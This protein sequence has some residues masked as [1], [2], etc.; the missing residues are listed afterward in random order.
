[1]CNS[2][3]DI[4]VTKY[5][6]LTKMYLYLSFRRDLT[7]KVPMW[8]QYW[9]IDLRIGVASI[10]IINVRHVTLSYGECYR[11]GIGVQ[12]RCYNGWISPQI[13]R[14]YAINSKA[15]ISLTLDS[16]CES[17]S[18]L[19][20]YSRLS[21]YV[22]TVPNW[23]LVRLGHSDKLC[24]HGDHGST[25]EWICPL[26]GLNWLESVR[27][28]N[29]KSPIHWIMVSTFDCLNQVTVDNIN[30]HNLRYSFLVLKP[31]AVMH[32]A[33]VCLLSPYQA[34]INGEQILSSQRTVA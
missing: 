29:S 16:H 10:L 17:D 5:D 20:L 8:R 12:V 15:A 32:A 14:L 19:V 28:W 24:D 18:C 21:S 34:L 30:P 4:T 3:G 9:A 7:K 6:C 22:R 27:A 33:Q 1:M 25:I 2:V 11:A 26:C 13:R 23:Y 31:A